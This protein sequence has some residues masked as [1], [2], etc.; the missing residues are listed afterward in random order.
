MNVAQR[1]ID[2]IGNTPVQVLNNIR[3]DSEGQVWGKLEYLGPGSS[4]KDRIAKYMVEKAEDSG[5]LRPGF[6]IIEATAGNTGV[7]LALVAA[8]KGYDF[9]CI[10]PQKF[11]KEKQQLIEFMGGK[12]LRTP[13][14]DGMKGAIAKAIQIREELG[15]AWIANQFSNSDNPLCHYQTT[16]REIWEQTEGRVTHIALGAGTGGTFSGVSRFLKEK[17]PNVKCYVV[18]PQ[19]SIL[20]GGEY[21]EYWVEG[22]G[23]SFLPDTLD[24]SLADGVLSIPCDESK[25]MVRTLAEKEQ[26]LAGGSTGAN[27]VAAKQLARQGGPESLVVTVICDRME[28]YM[29]KGIMES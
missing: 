5:E 20:G 18:E 21:K 8:A 26:I 4:I 6:T 14:E 22:I 12:V 27:V 13:T 2:L 9:I 19:G 10:M 7:G 3:E 23:N 17:N 24:M 25:A 28:R 29:S 15:K 11:S 1:S 16:G